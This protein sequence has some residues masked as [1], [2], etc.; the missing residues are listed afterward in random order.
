MPDRAKIAPNLTSEGLRYPPG[1]RAEHKKSCTICGTPVEVI[2]DPNN[3]TG[4]GG[5]VKEGQNIAKNAARAVNPMQ[6]CWL[7]SP[8]EA[9]ELLKDTRNGPQTISP[10]DL[11]L[12][13]G[14]LSYLGASSGLQSQKIC[15]YIYKRGLF[16]A[17]F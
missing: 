10:I 12:F 2:L 8:V 5:G 14:S 11:S 4:L 1:V 15:M 6:N 9:P 3:L 13:P 7:R 16:W 17:I